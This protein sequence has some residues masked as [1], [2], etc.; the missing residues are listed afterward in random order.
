MVGGRIAGAQVGAGSAEA[1]RRVLSNGDVRAILKGQIGVRL[2]AA[3]LYDTKG[4]HDAAGRLRREAD[5]HSRYL[6][7]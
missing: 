7:R 4:Q 3:A 6:A 5:A 2:A 1:E